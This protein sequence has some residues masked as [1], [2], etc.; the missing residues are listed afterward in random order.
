L[1]YRKDIIHRLNEAKKNSP[2]FQPQLFV[3]TLESVYRNL[4]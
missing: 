2:L 4:I 1:P 3:K